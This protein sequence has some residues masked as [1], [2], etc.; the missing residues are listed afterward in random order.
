M[1]S[2]NDAACPKYYFDLR[3]ISQVIFFTNKKPHISQIAVM[4]LSYFF[5]LPLKL[6]VELDTFEIYVLSAHTT[7]DFGI[8]CE[9]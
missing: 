8:S 7:K 5:L 2:S 9:T 4:R 6:I 3:K 1:I